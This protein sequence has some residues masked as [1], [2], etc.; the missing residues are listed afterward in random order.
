MNYLYKF[1]NSSFS[2]MLTIQWRKIISSPPACVKSEGNKRSLKIIDTNNRY[3]VSRKT[4]KADFEDKHI[5]GVTHEGVDG[6]YIHRH[7]SSA[8]P[9]QSLTR[10]HQL[11]NPIAYSLIQKFIQD[12]ILKTSGLYFIIFNLKHKFKNTQMVKFMKLLNMKIKL[13]YKIKIN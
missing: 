13:K 3:S 11:G 7:T 12:F 10:T 2:F 6:I 8:M 9:G 1:L 4:Q 5:E